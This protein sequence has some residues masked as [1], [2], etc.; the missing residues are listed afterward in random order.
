MRP[1]PISAPPSRARVRALGISLGQLPP[2]PHNA[3]TDVPGVEV[4]YATV[5]ADRPRVLR[6]GVTVIWPCRD[7][8]ERPRFAGFHSFNGN[9]EMTGTHWIAEQGL[10]TTP[11]GITN[12][13]SVGLVRDAIGAYAARAGVAQPWMLPVAAE[14]YDGTLSD[15]EAMGVT[16]EHAFAA[17]DGARGGAIAEGNVGGGTGMICHEFK[18]G[19]G[20]ASR[21]V[22]GDAGRFHIGA[23]VQAN[24]GMREQLRVDGVPVGRR[25]GVEEVP[26][27]RRK[28]T[29]S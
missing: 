15:A 1:M 8:W 13:H 27:P 14:T 22:E 24:Y 18:G 5:I 28:P 3:I 17:L 10:L 29:E 19:T 25:I 23:L 26:S 6:T 12:T 21:L 2:G 11:I 7:V 4:G 9:G 20:T 16:F